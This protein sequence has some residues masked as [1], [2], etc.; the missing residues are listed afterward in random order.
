MASA[1]PNNP[2]LTDSSA[3]TVPCSRSFFQ[4]QLQL[5]ECAQETTWTLTNVDTNDVVSS[6]G[7][8]D[9]YADGFVE[10]EECLDDGCYEFTIFD[11]YGDGICCI[12]GDGYYTLTFNGAVIQESDGRFN[13]FES[14]QFGFPNPNCAGQIP[15]SEPTSAPTLAQ[16]S[17]PTSAQTCV[18]SD[19]P[20]SYQGNLV[21]CIQVL[22]REQCSNPVAAS[23]CALTCDACEDYS[24]EDSLAPWKIGT[25][26]T[27]C[28]FFRTL[29]SD[30]IAYYCDRDD[31][32]ST[33][34][35]TCNFCNN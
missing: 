6:G 22:T 14:T 18:D 35:G 4:F 33:C 29:D 17:A 26:V 20:I 10:V 21:R 23:H 15:T 28:A 34:R 8:Y 19:P 24:C 3:R 1:N 27:T 25:T 11:D 5:D 31:I 32:S 16:S 30:E 13:S 2:Q 7:P 9:Y 12:D